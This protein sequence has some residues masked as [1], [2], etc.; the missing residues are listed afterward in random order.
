MKNSRLGICE[1]REEKRLSGHR[2][3]NTAKTDL[4][5]VTLLGEEKN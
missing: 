4:G 5:A 2:T 3:E 1:R